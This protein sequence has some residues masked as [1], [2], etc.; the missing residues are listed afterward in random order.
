MATQ[1]G[2][3]KI[4]VSD[5]LSINMSASNGASAAEMGLM[6]GSQAAM[7]VGENPAAPG[8]AMVMVGPEGVGLS[9]VPLAS[10][11]NAAAMVNNI[12]YL[13]ADTGTSPPALVYGNFW[14]GVD[15][16]VMSVGNSEAVYYGSGGFNA[17]RFKTSPVAQLA[18]G[19]EGA[20]VAGGPP[21]YA[22]FEFIPAI[23]S[24]HSVA[25]GSADELQLKVGEDVV[26]R[27]T[28]PGD[29][30]FGLSPN[31]IT[32]SASNSV[33]SGAFGAIV[34]GGTGN[35][36]NTATGGMSVIMGGLDN[37]AAGFG[38]V[39]GGSSNSATNDSTTV[40]G[41]ELNSATARHSTVS[42]GLLN[43]ASGQFSVVA[44]GIENTA[45]GRWSAIPGGQSNQAGGA[46]SVAAGSRAIVRDA[47]E[48]GEE[49][50]G[51]FS[52]DEG[53]FIWGDSFD[54]NPSAR[55]NN[56]YSSGPNQFIVRAAGG[57]WFG[58]KLLDTPD[59]CGPGGRENAIIPSG[60]FI[61]TT[62][63]AQ[64]C[65]DTCN[66]TYDYCTQP[67]QLTACIDGCNSNGAFLSTGGT[68]TNASDRNSKENV[69]PVQPRDVLDRVLNLGISRWNYKVEADATRH[70]G[71]MAQDFHAAF[72]VG[73]SEKTIATIDADGVA[74]AAIQGLHEIVKEKDCR[75]NE[76]E[77]RLA[78]LEALIEA[79]E[80]ESKD[81]SR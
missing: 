49:E 5:P 75:I 28:A 45:S 72:G 6:Y 29:S 4:D 59:A 69:E 60:R 16:A 11:G 25:G 7:K 40:A 17:T 65:A 33:A 14:G 58:Q 38:T 73:D 35:Y 2:S 81:G 51:G 36:P 18:A 26:A 56:T 77:Q 76:L 24:E 31:F 41:G 3:L 13:K 20:A 70:I 61:Q 52:G 42:G 63:G 27:W 53:T 30:G 44:G 43:T 34:A 37:V 12:A 9:P 64:T 1:L 32:G 66:T 23:A 8:Q 74:L 22:S 71:P 48:L 21:L 79:R 80:S 50:G 47:A 68:W 55:I 15:T 67:A 62:A 19:S 78:R 57:L 46:H 10:A 39:G 54:E